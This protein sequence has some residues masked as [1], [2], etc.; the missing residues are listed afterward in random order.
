MQSFLDCEWAWI[1]N[2]A[3]DILHLPSSVNVH[4]QNNFSFASFYVLRYP[5]VTTSSSKKTD[6]RKYWKHFSNNEFKLKHF[7]FL[8][9]KSKENLYLIRNIYFRN[10]DRLERCKKCLHNMS[11]GIPEDTS[12]SLAAITSSLKR[13]FALSSYHVHFIP[14]QFQNSFCIPRWDME[15][16]FSCNIVCKWSSVKLT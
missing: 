14:S 12:F 7:I 8:R 2:N 4:H 3:S 11:I 16:D 9:F 6:M 15:R 13:I 10:E 1:I 5:Q